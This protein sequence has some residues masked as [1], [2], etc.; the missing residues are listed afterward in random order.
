M[1]TARS[2]LPVSKLA[3]VSKSARRLAERESG[4][5]MT[6]IEVSKWW[7]ECECRDIPTKL[8]VMD[9]LLIDAWGIVHRLADSGVRFA[10]SPQDATLVI[11]GT[12]Y[13]AWRISLG[14]RS[15]A[16]NPAHP[17]LVSAGISDGLE[18]ALWNK[19]GI[20]AMYADDYVKEVADSD[21][22]IDGMTPIQVLA[23]VWP[24]RYVSGRLR[25]AKPRYVKQVDGAEP[26][27][28]EEFWDHRPNVLTA[29]RS[30]SR[31]AAATGKSK[32]RKA[33]Q[34]KSAR[35]KP[36]TKPK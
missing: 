25:L 1:K 23:Q 36:R 16:H 28:C 30:E 31:R 8:A 15:R 20:P 29:S 13:A 9:R 22:P 18:F 19:S 24:Q 3:P 27:W 34:A 7:D 14:Q 32:W 21:D 11:A 17:V 10:G 2:K 35:R 26:S 33:A 4:R 12:A 6:D 5:S